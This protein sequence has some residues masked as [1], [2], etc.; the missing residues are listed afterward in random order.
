LI[1][2]PEV[3][4]ARK[5]GETSL[6]ILDAKI[7]GIKTLSFNANCQVITIDAAISLNEVLYKI[8]KEIWNLL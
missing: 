7:N 1:A 5:P 4:E 3:I 2:S 8:K 6:E